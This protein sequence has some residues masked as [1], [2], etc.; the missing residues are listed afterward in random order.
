[1]DLRFT[2]FIPTT[3]LGRNHGMLASFFMKWILP[4]LAW[5]AGRKNVCTMDEGVRRI[6]EL[7]TSAELA[8]VSGAFYKDGERTE[9]KGCTNDVDKQQELWNYSCKVVGIDTGNN[10]T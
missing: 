1:M 8:D 9:S 10:A 4:T 7:T 3:D 6:A 5:L 2:G